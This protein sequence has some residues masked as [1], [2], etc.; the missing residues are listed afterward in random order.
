MKVKLYALILL[1]ALFVGSVSGCSEQPDR[2]P[3]NHHQ[4]DYVSW[5]IDEFELFGFTKEELAEKFRGK[6]YLSE[7]DKAVAFKDG[8]SGHFHLSFDKEKRVDG[9]ERVFI[10][11]AGCEIHGPFLATKRQAL[12]FTIN[13]LTENKTLDKEDTAKLEAAQALLKESP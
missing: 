6:L 5:G 8:R 13:G 3:H 9:V 1:G 7:D 10:D 2:S 11:G 4:T 12:E